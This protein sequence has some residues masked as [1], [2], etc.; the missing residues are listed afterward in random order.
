MMWCFCNSKNKNDRLITQFVTYL[1]AHL[2]PPLTNLVLQYAN[3]SEIELHVTK[4]V[5]LRRPMLNFVHITVYNVQ[6]HQSEVI[7]SVVADVSYC[8]M[9]FELLFDDTYT[10][11]LTGT[12][13]AYPLAFTAHN[14]ADFIQQG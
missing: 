3:T 12:A 11:T 8:F 4:E 2:L 5:I 7:F 13:H 9:F 1:D 6:I 14:C 10:I